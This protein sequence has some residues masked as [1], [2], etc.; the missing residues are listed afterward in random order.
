MDRYNQIQYQNE[1]L[2]LYQAMQHQNQ[3]MNYRPYYGQQ[4][5][6]SKEDVKEATRGKRAY[7]Q[8][9]L[10]KRKSIVEKVEK[11]GMT[12]KDAAI[13]LGI[14]YSTAKHIM[15][16]YR[17]SG[18]V[19]TKIMMKR[20]T[21]DLSSEEHYYDRNIAMNPLMTMQN[22][23]Q[24]NS[25][26]YDREINSCQLPIDEKMQDVSFNAEKFDDEQI[27]S[28]HSFLFKSNLYYR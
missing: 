25:Y 22:I 10:W 27:E 16:V 17:K 5:E 13:E 18:D 14:N 23:P 11:G 8:C 2:M 7:V 24:A 1:Q 20:K 4:A 6:D 12:I 28:I 26:Y 21:K 15:K 19:E 3:S 9:E